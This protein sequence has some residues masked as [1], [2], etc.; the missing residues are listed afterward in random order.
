MARL[1]TYSSG[2]RCRL[3]STNQGKVIDIPFR[4]ERGPTDLL[5]ALA[6]TVGRD[7]TAPHY[8]FHD[9]PALEPITQFNK[10]SYAL[11]KEQGKRAAKYFLT[12]YPHLFY[13]DDAEPKV[14]AFNP[15]DR[16]TPDVKCVEDDII[17]SIKLNQVANAVQCYKNCVE[18]K[19]PISQETKLM[20][21]ELCC[22]SNSQDLDYEWIEEQ[23]YY[24]NLKRN[25]NSIWMQDSLADSLFND[26][27]ENE[28]SVNALICG[29]ARHRSSERAY[30]LYKKALE[31]QLEISLLTYNEL[32]GCITSLS[33]SGD[34]RWNLT[35]EILQNMRQNKVAPNI[36]TFNNILENLSLT[37]LWKDCRSF[38]LRI[39]NEMASLDIEPS[40]ASYNFLIRIFTESKTLPPQPEILY[41]VMTSLQEQIERN[42][43]K[44][45]GKLTLRNFRDGMFFPTAMK[46]INQ[47]LNDLELAFQLHDILVANPHMMDTAISEL[48]YYKEFFLLLAKVAHIDQ[49]MKAYD[50]FVPHTYVPDG[51]MYREILNSVHLDGKLDLIPRLWTDMVCYGQADSIDLM[52]DLLEIITREPTDDEIIREQMTKVVEEIASRVEEVRSKSVSGQDLVRN[53]CIKYCLIN[54]KLVEGRKLLSELKETDGLIEGD[55]IEKFISLAIEQKDTSSIVFGLTLARF[56][57]NFESFNLVKNCLGSLDEKDVNYEKIKDLVSQTTNES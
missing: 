1:I 47:S 17:I 52:K 19:V 44:N 56:F 16:V 41:S 31:N 53:L 23:W 15:P 37:P 5:K 30:S 39:V 29:Y 10:V 46:K 54:G 14:P 26:L 57:E 43:T 11:S 3:F 40:L 55:L 9:D 12:N 36:D 2:L 42:S 45:G 32:L 35:E 20:L 25:Q 27:G 7:P 22:F 50:T 24:G 33:S 6:Q 4:I 21:F 51:N 28:A 18:Q 49:L 48:N 8:K 34:G 38:A 13:R